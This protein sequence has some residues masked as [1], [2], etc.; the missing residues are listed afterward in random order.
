MKGIPKTLE[1]HC[2]HCNVDG[3]FRYVSSSPNAD[4]KILRHYYC[5]SCGETYEMNNLITLGNLHKI[6]TTK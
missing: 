6:V 3:T 4:D 2:Q 1:G 5:H